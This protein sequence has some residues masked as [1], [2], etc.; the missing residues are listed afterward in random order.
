MGGTGPFPY[1][2]KTREGEEEEE[3]EKVSLSLSLLS[4]SWTRLTRIVSRNFLK[5]KEPDARSLV[6]N[7][8]HDENLPDLGLGYA[9]NG[10]G[11]H[12]PCPDGMESEDGA[13][14]NLI[15]GPII[16]GGRGWGM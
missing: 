15:V 3:E 7:V 4:K 8:P 14:G 12:H 6:R 16:D 11:D 2:H 10:K 5:P 1:S 9:N 13:F